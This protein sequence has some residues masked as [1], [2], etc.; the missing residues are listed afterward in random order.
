MTL[1]PPSR[2]KKK[3]KFDWTV[4]ICEQ[5]LKGLTGFGSWYIKDSGS[6]WFQ[7]ASTTYQVKTRYLLAS[8][9]F[10]SSGPS[11]FIILGNEMLL[12]ILLDYLIAFV[13]HA[14]GRLIFCLSA[15]SA[16]SLYGDV[17][18]TFIGTFEYYL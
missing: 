3:N 11:Y 1:P 7:L 13:L 14:V 10:A 6:V 2:K 15:K 8:T 17:H 9:L 5:T 16:E 18:D 4:T 12:C